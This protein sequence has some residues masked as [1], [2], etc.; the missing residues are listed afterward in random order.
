MHHVQLVG[1]MGLFVATFVHIRRC[2]LC[3]KLA[4]L[5]ARCLDPELIDLYCVN[6][7]VAHRYSSHRFTCTSWHM[8]PSIIGP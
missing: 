6:L 7:M 5:T 3:T 8:F 4:A 1:V 2:F